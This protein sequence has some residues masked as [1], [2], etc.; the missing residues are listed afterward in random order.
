MSSFRLFSARDSCP[1][2]VVSDPAYTTVT[3]RT[4][5]SAAM[6]SFSWRIASSRVPS[7]MPAPA[8]PGSPA[9]PGLAPLSRT[10]CAVAKD[11]PPVA[12]PTH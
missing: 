2:A 8:F 6:R 11:T 7:P 9:C 3:N 1:L 5:G 12:T 10:S 4:F